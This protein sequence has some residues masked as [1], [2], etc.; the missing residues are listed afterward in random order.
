MISFQNVY[1]PLQRIERLI[2]ASERAYRRALAQPRTPE[3]FSSERYWISWQRAGRLRWRA[4]DEMIEL[5]RVVA[6]RS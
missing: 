6:V 1:V 2:R 3:G 5:A 4:T